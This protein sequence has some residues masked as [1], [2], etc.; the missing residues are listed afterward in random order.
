MTRAKRTFTQE[1]KD[2]TF[3]LWK[4]GIGFSDIA[5]VL[6]AAPGTVFSA[7]RESG[8]IKPK[9]R[10]RNVQHLTLAEREEIR[11]AL[12][13]KL[14]LRAIARMLNR[15]PSIISREVARNRG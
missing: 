12:S 9:P 4:Q 1:E 15:S 14:S 13:M 11:V 10:T 3:N 8:G 2:L 5:K 6:R 7:L